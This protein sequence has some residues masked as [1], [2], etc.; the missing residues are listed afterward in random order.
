LGRLTLV[1]AFWAAARDGAE[2]AIFFQFWQ[3]SADLFLGDVINIMQGV[4][5]TIQN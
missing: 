1:V 3:E 2:K 4:N 5:P